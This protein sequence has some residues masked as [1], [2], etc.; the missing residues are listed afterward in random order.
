VV[1]WPACYAQIDNDLA[2]RGSNT[3]ILGELSTVLDHYVAYD[4]NQTLT[5]PYEIQNLPYRTPL[6]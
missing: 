1:L 6:K 4:G 2:H 3:W 5:F